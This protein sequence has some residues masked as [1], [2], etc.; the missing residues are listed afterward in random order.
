MTI[1]T[2]WT[3]Q[4]LWSRSR[5]RWCGGLMGKRDDGKTVWT[6]PPVSIVGNV[7]T[8][9]SGSVYTVEGPDM[10]GR[11]K[12]LADFDCPFYLDTDGAETWPPESVVPDT[13]PTD[14]P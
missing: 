1:L 5:S 10:W 3:L 4:R 2:N 13:R 11:T 7:V 9:R 8:T 12:T 6:G 14:E